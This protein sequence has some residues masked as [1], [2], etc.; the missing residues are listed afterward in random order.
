MYIFVIEYSSPLETNAM[1][2][3]KIPEN[4][5]PRVLAQISTFVVMRLGDR[6]DRDII[7]SN[8]KQDQ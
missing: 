4:V 6:D 7:I 5:D 3:T 8:D 2:M 1:I